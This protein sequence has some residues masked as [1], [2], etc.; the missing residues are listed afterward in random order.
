MVSLMLRSPKDRNP[1]FE[2][3]MAPKHKRDIPD[4]ENQII[5][6]YSLGLSNRRCLIKEALFIN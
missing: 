5:S 2:P 1:D 4:I 6:L 3:Q